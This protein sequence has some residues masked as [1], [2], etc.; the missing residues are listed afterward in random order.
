[1]IVSHRDGA[2]V[3]IVSPGLEEALKAYKGEWWLHDFG[4][5]RG[6]SLAAQGFDYLTDADVASPSEIGT[7]PFYTSFRHRYDIGRFASAMLAPL[8]S[9]S[10][11]LAV[12][13]SERE[14]DFIPTEMK[15]L[16]VIAPHVERALVLDARLGEHQLVATELAE[17]MSALNCGIVL[18]DQ[19]GH[20]TF[21]NTAVVKLL[22]DRP[23][24]IGKTLTFSDKQA[25]EAY[26]AARNICRSGSTVPVCSKPFVISRSDRTFL[27]V[28][29]VVILGR[30]PSR[31]ILKTVADPQTL[32]V[33]TDP[34]NATS[35]DPAL[36]RDLLDITLGE[37]RL[38]SLIGTGLG[39]RDAAEQLNITESTARV[40]L[41]RVFAKTGLTR[42]SQ[43]AAL[44]A[45]LGIL[46]SSNA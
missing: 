31:S 12:Q 8:A 32:L 13:R 22:G 37:A 36:V 34:A 23:P 1:M 15:Q 4:V 16:Q 43:L 5:A 41:K 46:P 7:H 42:Q 39:P 9:V 44:L 30:T 28:G 14:G 35:I 26:I 38:A 29:Q 25:N 2:P 33:I 6:L 24:A 3:T 45:R 18:T 21:T 40:V 17:A 19:R 27:L 20:V 11:I 10:V